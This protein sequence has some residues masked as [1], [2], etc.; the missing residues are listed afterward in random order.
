MTHFETADKLNAESTASLDAETGTAF[1]KLCNAYYV[2]R[3]TWSEFL[4][5]Y[6]N[7]RHVDIANAAGGLFFKLT[8]DALFE[9]VLLYLSRFT[10]PR[11][12]SGRQT[13]SLQTLRD[14]SYQRL[15]TLED[16]KE[17]DRLLE[18]AKRSADFARDWRHR[19]IGHSD[20]ELAVGGAKPLES[21]TQ[22]KVDA[23]IQAVCDVLSF[24]SVRLVDG[25]ALYAGVPHATSPGVAEMLFVLRD[26]LDAK[27]ARI[28]RIK[29]G[30]FTV[31]DINRP[32]L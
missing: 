8:E 4:A 32:P 30:T 31:N 7:N 5:L 13:V 19:H 10:D 28:E 11:N 15:A 25:V 22:D 14:H 26:G 20:L 23:A 12:V 29:S 24:V 18:H 9:S 6:G 1:R 2:L 17:L 27:A 16:R 21:A 3:L